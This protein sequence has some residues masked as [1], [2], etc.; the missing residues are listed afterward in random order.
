[1]IL[2][3]RVFNIVGETTNFNKR[4]QVDGNKFQKRMLV[5]P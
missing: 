2:D 3:K 4:V 1:M 5:N